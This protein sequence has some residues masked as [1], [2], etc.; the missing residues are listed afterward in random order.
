MVS[1]LFAHAE[2][3]ILKMLFIDLKPF[4]NVGGAAVRHAA[5]DDC[6]LASGDKNGD[7]C[8]LA[9]PSAVFELRRVSAVDAGQI[10]DADTVQRLAQWFLPDLLKPSL[11]L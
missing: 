11:T 3:S 1:D 2:F 10:R 7:A 4:V 8:A 9:P 6:E 5:D